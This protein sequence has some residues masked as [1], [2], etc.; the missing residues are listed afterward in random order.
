MASTHQLAAIMFTDI[1]GY[2]KL[3][4]EDEV[5][6]MD[7]LKRNREIHQT[8]IKNY[9]GRLLKEMGDGILA[10]FTSVL[11][12]V[13]CAGKIQEEARNADYPLKIG[14][15]LGE[16]LVENDDVYGDGVNIASRIQE[17]GKGGQILVS[18]TVHANIENKPGIT[19]RFQEEKQLKNVK[20]PVRIYAI[21]LDATQI[22]EPVRD[23]EKS[24][25]KRSV[26]VP[27]FVVLLVLFATYFLYDKFWNIPVNKITDKSIAVLP[28]KN[29][30]NDPDKQYLAD[31]TM[32]AILNNLA[33]IKDIKVMSRTST[34]QYRDDPKDPREIGKELDVAYVLE[35]SFQMYGEKARLIVQL[36]STDDGSHKWSEEFDRDWKDI[37]AV[38]SEVA[39]TI[40]NQLQAVITPEEKERIGK[41]P[42]A[43]LTAYD[44][45][46]RGQ[47]YME[48]YW[49]SNKGEEEFKNVIIAEKL[50]NQ[51]LQIDSGFARAWYGKAH[52]VG[53]GPNPDSVIYYNKMAIS[54]DPDLDDAYGMLGLY[55]AIKD[56]LDK[57][58]EYGEKAIDLNPN[59][60]TSYW[61]L[62]NIHRLL[63]NYVKAMQY[64]KRSEELARGGDLWYHR[65]HTIGMLYMEI[66][67][68]QKAREY[69]RRAIR[70]KPDYYYSRL[71]L[72]D[73]EAKQNNIESALM[74]AD[75]MFSLKPNGTSYMRMMLYHTMLENFEEA[76]KALNGFIQL[77]NGEI[78]A[79]DAYLA[80]WVYWK[81]GKREKSVESFNR[82]I[83][84]NLAELESGNDSFY[85]RAAVYAFL[86]R[87]EEAIE[88]LQE[89][90][91]GTADFILID[92]M[93]EN[94]WEEEEF[95]NL[96]AKAQA[97]MAEIRDEIRQMEAEGEL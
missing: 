20:D 10:S 78:P 26:L 4:G 61:S 5:K 18:E 30:S 43:D 64:F 49:L 92:P 42:T 73:L 21:D 55:Y 44:I 69:L 89:H 56:S 66:G 7:I 48:D 88:A 1:V 24:F 83:D 79:R 82:H 6:T 19:S 28:F 59:N 75:T 80:G 65:I 62:G 41:I 93:F 39:Q 58:L 53:Q 38:Q 60:E 67:A 16:I 45:Y 11:D 22:P 47:Q 70:L 94:L 63:R 9:N 3:M 95:Q 32:D 85:R 86:D 87:R 52:V 40:A 2:T 23:R 97:E 81:L 36:I 74:Y 8:D 50:F 35:G 46:L 71:E 84:W 13:H 29:L 54:F 33:K 31:G 14:I 68:Y 37:F 76:E 27:A 51:A 17:T 25:S 34:L 12:A 96:V 77:N 72:A 57:A 90:S 91:L 15:H